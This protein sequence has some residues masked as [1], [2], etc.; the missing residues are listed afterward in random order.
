MG[1]VKQWPKS[2]GKSADMPNLNVWWSAEDINVSV[3]TFY[4]MKIRL[5]CPVELHISQQSQTLSNVN[6]DVHEQSPLATLT[7]FVFY[8]IA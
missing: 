5:V 6:F 1:M 7:P 3:N 4:F 2:A 8:C